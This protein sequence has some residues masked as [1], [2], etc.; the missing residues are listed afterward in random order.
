MTV[1]QELFADTLPTYLTRFVGRAQELQDLV[2]LAR[3]RLVTICALPIFGKTRLAIELAK[4]LRANSFA[5]SQYSD[6]FWVPLVGVTNSADVPA[7]VAAGIGLQGPTGDRAV[8]ALENTLRDRPA[9][10]VL[11]NCEHVA[12]E[13]RELLTTLLDRCPN[14]TVLTTSR[15]PLGPEN[16][17][18]YVVPAKRDDAID[19]FA[20]RAVR[21]APTYALTSINSSTISDVCE[22]LGGLPLAIELAASWINILSP[23][24][25]LSKI[26]DT[27]EVPSH[28]PV[29]DRHRSMHGV[30]DSSW[31]WLS[32]NDRTVLA[33]LGVFVGGFTHE[34]AAE[35]AGAT[36]ASL[37][38]LSE[39]A[40]IQRLPDTVGGSRY[41][42]HELVRTYA[43][44][45][46]EAA[47]PE[48]AKAVRSRHFDY[49][50]RL[51]EG[52]E[53][54]WNTPIEP[55]S[56]GPLGA[57]QGN[58]DSAMNW[59][60]SEGE[61]ERALRITDAL[62]A[63]YPY[64]LP[65]NSN[66][67]DHIYRALSI[68]WTDSRPVGVRA[69]A[70]ALNRAGHIEVDFDPEGAR[71]LFRQA[72][73]LFESVD[74]RVGVAASVRGVGLSYF[75]EGRV[76]A[77]RRYVK[78]GL[79][80]AEAAGDSQGVAW[81]YYGLADLATVDGRLADARKNFDHAVTLFRQNGAP[82][83]Q[84]RAHIRLTNVNRLDGRWQESVDSARSALD[85]QR[86]HRFTAESADLLEALALTA[87]ALREFESAARLA[88]AGV[89]WRVAYDEPVHVHNLNVAEQTHQFRAHLGD[90]LWTQAYEQGER[91]TPEGAVAL[92]GEVIEHLAAVLAAHP[93]G[94]SER[95]MEVL[96]LVADGLD[97]SA[98][99]DHL[100][101]SPRTVH[102]HLRSVYAKLGV[103]T[104]TAA[105]HEAQ[106]LH[107]V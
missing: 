60:L 5:H 82:F 64:S 69:R 26:D 42:V 57:E 10:L 50:L 103:G 20:E 40:L 29:E 85:L 95:E 84:Y 14:L 41:Q 98:I 86:T 96:R 49:F 90:D 18:V 25:L 59:A 62:D 24:D 106:R 65:R 28:G 32:E 87:G 79:D 70:K 46:L 4:I 58:L 74:D 52:F 23:R 101:L 89:T 15:I 17:R 99:A 53:T 93:A 6:A 3:F 16:E 61:A 104:R 37:T 55:E 19:L 76:A 9:L 102:A 38:A 66:R 47:G 67:L 44:G 81:C 12:A 94:L 100:V 45:R 78:D 71:K 30:L 75:F 77:F 48:V 2:I 8:L 72:H 88:G 68:P 56:N 7:A 80:L 22:R 105:A 83:G 36:L 1:D 54:S 35:V 31:Q 43:L 11:D 34:A 51:A 13:C 107:L 97:N 21:A 63:F 91:L 92:A 39:R 33:A 27:M 73:P